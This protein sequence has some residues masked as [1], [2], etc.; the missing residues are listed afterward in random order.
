[1]FSQVGAFPTFVFPALHQGF[2]GESQG[3]FAVPVTEQPIEFSAY[4]PLCLWRLCRCHFGECRTVSD[5]EKYLQEKQGFLDEFCAEYCQR[6][7]A[8]GY[9][10]AD[11]F[12]FVDETEDRVLES[13]G[14]QKQRAIGIV[15]G[16]EGMRPLFPSVRD[17]Q[18][19]SLSVNEMYRFVL[20]RPYFEALSPESEGRLLTAENWDGL[21]YMLNALP[22]SLVVFES[23]F[24]WLQQQIDFCDLPSLIRALGYVSHL[25]ECTTQEMMGL[26]CQGSTLLRPWWTHTIEA[27]VFSQLVDRLDP[28]RE[29]LCTLVGAAKTRWNRRLPR[30]LGGR[31]FAAHSPLVIEKDLRAIQRMLLSMP[32]EIEQAFYTIDA[33]TLLFLYDS[34]RNAEWLGSEADA[35]GELLI[36]YIQLQRLGIGNKTLISA[37]QETREE[38]P[39]LMERPLFDP[40][41]ALL[42]LSANQLQE[43]KIHSS[44]P[45]ELKRIFL[46]MAGMED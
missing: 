36:V 17:D 13:F 41:L 26:L 21:V 1:M 32:K 22:P 2:V 8:T 44:Q 35:L 7:K 38:I 24:S 20:A 11:V 37:L 34:T 18:F 15:R 14:A 23:A 28:F 6:A 45:R 27:H 9:L 30:G 33:D 39:F 4:K 40:C 10:D 29:R 43:L 12:P 31:L 42:T 5:I 19:S 46:S 3:G 25:P 16:F